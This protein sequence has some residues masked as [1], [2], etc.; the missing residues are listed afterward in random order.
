MSIAKADSWVD[1]DGGAIVKMQ[2]GIISIYSLNSF[3]Y[4]DEIFSNVRKH[5]IKVRV[6]LGF[7]KP[8]HPKDCG[9]EVTTRYSMHN[10]GKNRAIHA[11]MSSF[12]FIV[13]AFAGLLEIG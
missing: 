12:P 5:R 9:R 13:S 11:D 3:F 10:Q 1:D 4:F 7:N 8:K 2:D 6:C